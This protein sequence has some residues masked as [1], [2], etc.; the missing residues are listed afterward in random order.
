MGCD[1]RFGDEGMPVVLSIPVDAATLS[2]EDF[3]VT[4]AAGIEYQ[5][6][7]AT[8]APAVEPDE[9]RTI[10]LTGPLGTNA[11]RPQ[12]VTIVGSLLSLD[13]TE[14]MGLSSPI[15]RRE[16][17]PS[18]VLA[19][20]RTAGTDCDA[21]GAP[22][23]RIQTTWQGG[24]I[25][26]RGSTPGAT[27]RQGIQIIDRRGTRHAPRG[28]AD[29]NDGDNHI[30]LCLPPGVIPRRVEVEAATFYDPTNVPNPHT[31]VEVS[32]T[33]F[34]GTWRVWVALLF[35]VLESWLG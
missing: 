21:A 28:L 31:S 13:G 26:P 17:G 8:L 4:T 27:E 1:Q 15:T 30:V 3:R 16:E 11:D 7:C 18:L 33:P 24:V 12:T 29:L 9:L 14:L 10:L 22:H 25:G 2:P 23:I 34:E 32:P 35:V 5:P 6:T 19:L 20:C